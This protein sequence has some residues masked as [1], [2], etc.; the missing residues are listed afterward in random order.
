VDQGFY[1]ANLPLG[2][3]YI[4]AGRCEA[5]TIDKAHPLVRWDCCSHPG[6]SWWEGSE[7]Y[8]P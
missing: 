7:C 1:E 8:N 3:H 6:G 4:C 2:T 5:I